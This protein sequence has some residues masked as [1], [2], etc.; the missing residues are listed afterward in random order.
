MK[1]T[2]NPELDR[3]LWT[4]F[5][6][7]RVIGGPIVI[8]GLVWF[9]GSHEIDVP[10][11][12]IGTVQSMAYAV[13]YLWGCHSIAGALPSEMRN[14]SWDLQR[15]S[16]LSSWSIT[17]GKLL[18]PASYQWY[19]TFVML[20]I[21]L[22]CV[23]VQHPGPIQF[24]KLVIEV[25][26]VF[27]ACGFLAH[28]VSFLCS[29]NTSMARHDFFSTLIGA[30]FGSFALIS[31]LQYVGYNTGAGYI[32]QLPPAM[33]WNG[34]LV[35]QSH[36]A[37]GSI[38]FFSFWA[39]MGAQRMI[40]ARL[41][42][43]NT[44]IMWA[45]FQVTFLIY[46]TGFFD[47]LAIFAEKE[48][49][50]MSKATFCFFFLAFSTYIGAFSNA[51]NLSGYKRLAAAYRKQATMDFFTALPPWV[52]SAAGMI[53]ALAAVF[54]F[55]PGE[56]LAGHKQGLEMLCLSVTF[57]VVRDSAVFHLL[58]LSGRI[59]HVGFYLLVYMFLLY[60]L[61]PIMA[62]EI[63]HGVTNRLVGFFYPQDSHDFTVSVLPIALESLFA[64]AL[65][66][67]VL[68]RDKERMPS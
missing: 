33:H 31:A 2:A 64:L 29:I 15:M 8:A 52:V 49:I 55:A 24:A 56:M 46:V 45:L 30:G 25:P 51:D 7:G 58:F 19:C 44:P 37:F 66:K 9:F 3:N 18:G 34:M 38:A 20:L 1:L 68:G 27:L 59:R 23:M 67:S 16:A 40:R 57:L 32:M 36:L 5:S 42:Y 17:W 65:L 50:A 61:L 48:T 39:V 60:F 22:A 21:Y 53:P 54:V 62:G 28:G 4:E 12:I 6:W 63:P 43:K 26:A 41:Q 10:K 35:D 47:Q 11:T 14:Q 13:L